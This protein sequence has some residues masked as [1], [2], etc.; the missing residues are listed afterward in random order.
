MERQSISRWGEAGRCKPCE[1]AET[2]STRVH[3]IDYA[4]RVVSSMSGVG[5]TARTGETRLPEYQNVIAVDGQPMIWSR[6]LTGKGLIDTQRP[7][8]AQEARQ[9][10]AT[11]PSTDE[12]WWSAQRRGST[13]WPDRARVWVQRIAPSSE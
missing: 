3:K 12:A 11:C 4:P 10:R 7:D 5:S 13:E 6:C 8:V 1:T 9:W 2:S